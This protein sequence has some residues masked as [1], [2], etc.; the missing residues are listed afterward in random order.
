MQPGGA[1]AFAGYPPA[2]DTSFNQATQIILHRY[3]G[4]AITGNFV[5][6]AVTGLD[7]DDGFG[8]LQLTAYVPDPTSAACDPTAM[9]S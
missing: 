8:Q 6:Y 1:G 2:D 5:H 9:R 7:I 4:Q 3:A